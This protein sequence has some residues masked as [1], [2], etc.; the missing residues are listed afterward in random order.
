[1]VILHP[2]M[3]VGRWSSPSNAYLNPDV[4]YQ[5]NKTLQRAMLLDP[6]I[7]EPLRSRQLSVALTDWSV[8]PD[9]EENADQKA[10]C[11]RL[12]K[13]IRRCPKFV[14]LKM[15]LLEAIWF[16]RYAVEMNWY[17]GWNAAT[18]KPEMRVKDWIPV[19]GDKLT[20]NQKTKQLGVYVR[21]T[22]QP[23]L[24]TSY[25][26]EARIHWLEKQEERACFLFHQHEILDGDFFDPRSAGSVM[27]LGLRHRVWWPWFFKQSAQA[28]VMDFMQRVGTGTNIWYYDQDNPESF[29]KVK[30]AAEAQSS[31]TNI[32]FPRGSQQV[33]RGAG[34]ERIEASTG[35]AQF[36]QSL[37][38]DYFGGQ[39]KLMIA[40]QTLSSETGSTGMGSGVANAHESTKSQ[41]QIFDAANLDE[42]L[43]T[44]LLLPMIN[45]PEPWSQDWTPQYTSSVAEPDP[46]KLMQAA[47]QYFD[48]GG[49]IADDELRET[50]SLRKPRADEKVLSKAKS[51][52]Q[53]QPGGMPGM[54]PEAGP[55]EGGDDEA[56]LNSLFPEESGGDEGEAVAA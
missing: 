33:G 45:Y 5:E 39:I 51:E 6:V 47:R 3:F 17:Y 43:T 20:I 36:L 40:G 54:P 19:Q 34:Y 49:E 13:Q 16:G 11:K 44:D 9:D 42:T 48:M 8:K 28:W 25:G 55:P 7:M 56:F 21:P 35:G 18:N 27:G 26:N 14:R 52:P 46:E 41:Y 15:A 12:E 24:A 32:I 4:A 53:G 22:E 23:G 31:T 1:M 37:L 10:I 29:E 38:E 30:D 50:A 2:S